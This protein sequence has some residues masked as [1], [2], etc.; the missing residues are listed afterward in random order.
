M[1]NRS[2]SS[3]LVF[4]AKKRQVQDLSFFGAEGEPLGFVRGSRVRAR[5]GN[6]GVKLLPY[7]IS[8]PEALCKAQYVVFCGLVPV[9]CVIWREIQA[10]RLAV[11]GI[12][13]RCMSFRLDAMQFYRIDCIPL[14]GLHTRNSVIKHESSTH[15]LKLGR[16]VNCP[17]FTAKKDR[18]MPILFCCV[19]PSSEP[20][21]FKNQILALHKCMP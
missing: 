9:F 3:N 20:I 10:D 16:G 15:P 6:S 21:G 11:Y 18:Q 17:L 7:A 5:G 4:C 14:C 1:G 2:T 12:A 8:N 13:V 19:L